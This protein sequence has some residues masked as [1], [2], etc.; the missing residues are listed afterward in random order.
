MGVDIDSLDLTESE[1]VEYP[2]AQESSFARSW[3]PVDLASVLDGTHERPTPS[4][5]RRSDDV[6]LFYPGK[7]HTVVSE[8]EGGKTWLALSAALDELNAGSHVV[9]IDFEDDEAGLVGRLLILGAHRDRIR[10][11][12]HYLRPTDPLGTGI[13]ADDLNDVLKTWVPTLGIVDGVTEAM[14]MHGLDPNKNDDA[15]RFGRML[16]KR[17]AATGAAAVSLDHVVK[18][19]D[20][21]GRYALGAAHKLNGID[22]CQYV[23]TNRHP[24]G[25]GVTGRST[26][27]IAKD[28]PAELRRHALP[29]AA[30]LHWFGD[31][32]LTSRDDTFA[33]VSVEPPRTGG[34]DRRP[35]VL[36]QRVADALEE[37][38]PLSKNKIEALVTGKADTIRRALA[39]LQI[40]G[41]VSDG[42]SPYSLLK[43]YR[44]G[45]ST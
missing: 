33:E 13:H 17:I 24:F 36:M 16:P 27:A 2:A 14:T 7:C 12:F 19:S 25:V 23:L 3:R 18:S 15:A 29:S 6:G 38:G 1:I 39:F 20:N 40:D 37:H 30:G 4:V 9:Y 42:V 43:P 41:Y 34:D 32:V 28:R 21:R 35:T 10:E 26:V 44:A 31:L 45:S 8:S 11:R 5:G 22:G